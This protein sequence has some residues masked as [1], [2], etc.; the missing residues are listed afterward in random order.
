M[1]ENN[2]TATDPEGLNFFARLQK[3]PAYFDAFTGHM[4]AWTA[5]KTPWTEI[6]DTTRLLEE[7]DYHDGAV[8]LVDMGGN[9][10]IDVSHIVNKHP[11]LPRESLI[12]QDLPEIID[13]VRG[14]L[15]E[16]VVVMVHDFFLPQVVRGRTI[17]T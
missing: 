10:G 6:Y 5:W 11:G 9:T 4:E 2:H 7:G 13:G 16:R 3:T 1:H 14:Q 8:F 17:S 15:E 12:L